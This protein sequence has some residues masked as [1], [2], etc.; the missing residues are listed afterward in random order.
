MN[1]IKRAC[2]ELGITKR[3]LAEK[4]GIAYTTSVLWTSKNGSIS[5]WA[6]KS[7][8]LLLEN[9]FLKKELENM[10]K[11][12]KTF[13]GII[14]DDFLFYRR[15]YDEEVKKN[16]ELEKRVS[17]LTAQIDKLQ[18]ENELIQQGA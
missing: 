14:L 13:R 8:A 17:E 18:R 15:K 12:G 11:E 6:S 3:E 5:K 7:I 9:H 16:A 4:I 1:L 2:L 10:E